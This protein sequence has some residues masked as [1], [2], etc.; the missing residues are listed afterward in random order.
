MVEF[1]LKVVKKD[2][3]VV[4]SDCGEDEVFL[5]NNNEYEEGDKIVLTTSKPN[6]YAVIQVDDALGEAFVY[7]TKTE[8][9][10]TIPFGEKRINM[11]PKVFYGNLH[12][13]TA[14]L[15]T[16]E[17]IGAYKNLALN[18]MDQHD[19]EGCY[20][21]AYANVETRGES[22]FA[23]KNAIDGVKENRSHGAWPYQSWGI[24]RQDDAW[25]TVDF[26]RMVEVDKI[27]LYTRADFPHDNWWT[28]VTFSFSDG[29]SMD[30]QM[31]KSIKPHVFTFE[32]K[33]ITWIR[34]EKMI[35]ADDPSPFPALTQIEVY[36]TEADRI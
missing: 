9:T 23:A 7:L 1:T 18:V 32:K 21:H 2:G 27:R 20:P 14:R 17:E 29:T 28:Q 4:C 26:G 31:E 10:Y 13:L 30:V 8:F 19:V 25:I 15:A 34:M 3:S 11:S 6:I 33:K 16:E 12:L 36:G 22:V 5:V 35:K 24:N